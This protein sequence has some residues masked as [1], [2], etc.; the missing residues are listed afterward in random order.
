LA[1]TYAPGL[2]DYAA[3]GLAGV[4]D[5]LLRSCEVVTLGAERSPL[6]EAAK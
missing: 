5:W 4:R 3:R 2:C 1:A 6:T